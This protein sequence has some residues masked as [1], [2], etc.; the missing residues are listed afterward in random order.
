RVTKVAPGSRSQR[1]ASPCRAGSKA[2]PR[3]RAFAMLPRAIRSRTLPST[4]LMTPLMENEGSI[5]HDPGR[6]S[7]GVGRVAQVEQLGG[8]APPPRHLQ[9]TVDRNRAARLAGVERSFERQDAAGGLAVRP[10]RRVVG[11][12]VGQ[13]RADDDQRLRAAPEA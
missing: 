6:V 12:I 4:P 1:S 7:R 10:L 13:I 11:E 3:P 5:A 8:E 2:G 9:Q